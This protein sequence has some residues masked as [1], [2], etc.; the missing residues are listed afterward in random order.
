M[1]D[2]T[3]YAGKVSS[4]CFLGKSVDAVHAVLFEIERNDPGLSVS[5]TLK[6]VSRIFLA[7]YATPPKNKLI[8]AC[9]KLRSLK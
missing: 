9:I 8:K 1:R 6:A 3:E 4:S 7:F 5:D 2:V